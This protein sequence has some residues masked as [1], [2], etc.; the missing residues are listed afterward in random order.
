MWSARGT[1]RSCRRVRSRRRDWQSLRLKVR[2]AR[3][4]SVSVALR[5]RHKGGNEGSHKLRPTLR[6]SPP[7]V[8]PP[9]G[10]I[11]DR[12]RSLR[13][14]AFP[15]PACPP[16]RGRRDGHRV[17]RGARLALTA[18][19]SLAN[20]KASGTRSSF[21]PGTA[22]PSRP[23]PRFAAWSEARARPHRRAVPCRLHAGTP[24]GQ[25]GHVAAIARRQRRR[26]GELCNQ[27]AALFGVQVSRFLR[28]REP[29]GRRPRSGPSGNEAGPSSSHLSRCSNRKAFTAASLLATGAEPVILP[30]EG[31]VLRPGAG[32]ALGLVSLPGTGQLRIARRGRSEK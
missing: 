32:S 14:E 3:H 9:G 2:G 12:W 11:P 8:S 26:R 4:G 24:P 20:P 27:C 16:A 19:L 1:L 25:H 22:R 21:A 28:A 31:S 30:C 5:P 17:L 29:H 23:R 18:A 6:Y 10:T 7:H 13:H 15:R